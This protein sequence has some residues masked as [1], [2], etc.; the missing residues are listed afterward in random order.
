[1]QHGKTGSEVPSPLHG[2]FQ[3]SDGGGALGWVGVH[4]IQAG[5]GQVR[6]HPAKAAQFSRN[7]FLLRRR[8]LIKLEARI[9]TWP[10]YDL[11]YAL[12][13]HH[14]ESQ[15]ANGAPGSLQAVPINRC[16]GPHRPTAIG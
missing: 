5:V 3:G 14:R 16:T 2:D 10:R 9:F 4:V 12:N 15:L 13:F 8:E 7:L 6:G 11:T 1:M